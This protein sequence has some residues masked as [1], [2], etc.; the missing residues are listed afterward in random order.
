MTHM[1]RR[2]F[3]AGTAGLAGA[4]A[5]GE[6]FAASFPYPLFD[7]HQH[8]YS[9]DLAKFPFAPPAGK[10]TPEVQ[11]GFV[12]NPMRADKVLAAW[13]AAG[14]GAGCGVQYRT[15]Y[16]VDNSYVLSVTDA[17]KDRVRAVVILDSVDPASPAKL[18]AL[19]HAHNV[20]AIRITGP[21]VDGGFPWLD[22]APALKTWQAA[23]DLGLVVELMPGPAT[24]AEQALAVRKIATLAVMFPKTRIVLDH[25]CFPTAAGAPE[26]GLSG[27][28]VDLNKH[29][30][31]YYK[32]TWLLSRQNPANFQGAPFLRRAVDLYG[33]DH[34]LWGSDNGNG[35]GTL[36]ERMAHIHG[37]VA[38]LTPA[39]TKAIL[40]ETG[41]RVFS[42]AKA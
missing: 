38:Q 42:V 23:N 5:A 10:I 3:L 33:A 27:D 12:K 1:H 26:Y 21:A 17:H 25:F 11:Q 32:Y 28:W 4:A 34:I 15:A 30:N 24:A 6:A 20:V 40:S 22:S 41:P 31:V 19:A 7:T 14:I 13:D 2:E 35:G 18:A 36:D 8:F 16:G 37:A 9:D 39:E 29:K